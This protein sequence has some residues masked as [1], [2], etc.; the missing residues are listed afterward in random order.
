MLFANYY[1]AVPPSVCVGWLLLNLRLC[2][3]ESHQ[4]GAMQ[5]SGLRMHIKTNFSQ[6]KGNPLQICSW[7]LPLKSKFG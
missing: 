1:I 6:L 3:G 2:F 7:Q 5:L 4:Q